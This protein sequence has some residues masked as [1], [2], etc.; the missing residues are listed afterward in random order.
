MRTTKRFTPD[1]LNRFR[2]EERGT[3]IYTE[4][5]PWHRIS[6]GDPASRG[7]SHLLNWRGRQRE[8][9]SDGELVITLFVTMLPGI[10]DLREQ[11]PLSL[12]TAHHELCDYYPGSILQIFPG[13]QDV[14]T[15]LGYKHPKATGKGKATPWVMSTDLLLVLKRPNGRLE[16]LAIAYKTTEEL[17]NRRTKQR[18]EIEQA[19]WQARDVK[20]LLITPDQFDRRVGLTLR[21]IAPWAL[22]LPVP[23]RELSLVAS[24]ASSQPELSLT[25]LLRHLSTV[26]GEMESAQR[27]LWQAV[28]LGYLPIDLTCG[29]R[30]HLPLKHLPQPAFLAQN[31]IA[32]RRSAWN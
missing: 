1:V 14:A 24:I 22:G 31:P 7:R 3:G 30:P 26:T 15:Q 5:I 27:A 12:D 29:W 19:Y 21:R 32:M 11:F 2:R 4:Y 17:K 10:D 28:C 13:T 25:S 16:L 8:L 20:W 9:L 6:R 18:L 23:T